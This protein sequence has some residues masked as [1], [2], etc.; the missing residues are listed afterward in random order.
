MSKLVIVE[1]PSKA[2]SIQKYLGS[3]YKVVSSKGH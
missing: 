3:G 2:K 1:S